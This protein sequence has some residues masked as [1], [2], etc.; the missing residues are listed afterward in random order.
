MLWGARIH[1]RYHAWAPA[2]LLGEN[3]N[4]TRQD[5]GSARAPTVVR[6]SHGSRRAASR[7]RAG[8]RGG[9]SVSASCRGPGRPCGRDPRHEVFLHRVSA[10]QR[11]ETGHGHGAGMGARTRTD[12]GVRERDAE[13]VPSAERGHVVGWAVSTRTDSVAAR[14]ADV[15]M[16]ALRPPFAIV[17]TPHSSSTFSRALRSE[18]R[19]ARPRA[20]RV[21]TLRTIATAASTRATI[22]ARCASS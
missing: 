21:S 5:L 18:R 2:R 19:R 7:S 14:T 13:S 11:R 12:A 8:R 22:S 6:F 10:R 15:L 1:F 20:G 3:R 16:R 4:E 17:I 9:P